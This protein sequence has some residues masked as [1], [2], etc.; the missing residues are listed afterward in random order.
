PSSST[1]AMSR[2]VMMVLFESEVR[3]QM[4]K[5]YCAYF[6]SGGHCYQTI[7]VKNRR[8]GAKFRAPG[9]EGMNI[10]LCKER[11]RSPA[12]GNNQRP[13]VQ[14]VP[15]RFPARDCEPGPLEHTV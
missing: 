3:M 9:G 2:R 15:R 6:A 5:Y 8:P 11:T 1:A 7:A 10:S 13:R 4:Q 14:R 12:V